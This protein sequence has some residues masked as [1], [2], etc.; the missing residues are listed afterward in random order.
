[1]GGLKCH[2]MPSPILD[3]PVEAA[4]IH[5]FY[6]IASFIKCNIAP[7]SGKLESE[8]LLLSVLLYCRKPGHGA[9]DNQ[10]WMVPLKEP[11][12]VQ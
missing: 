2:R 8:S 4:Y 6:T 12:H 5:H 10:L 1:M 11:I 9:I 3:L 7:F